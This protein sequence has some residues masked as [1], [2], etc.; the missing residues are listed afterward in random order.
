MILNSGVHTRALYYASSTE[1]FGECVLS[2]THASCLFGGVRVPV[3]L[4]FKYVQHILDEHGHKS[5]HIYVIRFNVTTNTK[6]I[7]IIMHH[8][9]TLE[10]YSYFDEY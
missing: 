3:L 5:F 7:L 2:H 9:V 1:C 6:L 10:L 4:L 8:V